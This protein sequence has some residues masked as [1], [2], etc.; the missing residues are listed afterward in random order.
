MIDYFLL[1]A[2]IAFIGLTRWPVEEMRRLY[3]EKTGQ[4]TWAITIPFI[5]IGYLKENDENLS[6]KRFL[7]I[8][9]IFFL[10]GITLTILGIILIS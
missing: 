6:L 2:G 4:T 7:I 10:L 5:V 1:I 9:W 3:L 8:F